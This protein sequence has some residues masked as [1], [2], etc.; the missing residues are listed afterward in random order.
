MNIGGLYNETCKAFLGGKWGYL[1]TRGRLAIPHR[2]DEAG[3]F[4]EN[5]AAVRIGAKWGYI[6]SAGEV[7]IQPGYDD[8]GEFRGGAALVWIGSEYFLI[9]REARTR[10]KS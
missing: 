7:V 10:G 9:D 4:S 2:Y 6:D 1:D 5:L 3:N 8:A